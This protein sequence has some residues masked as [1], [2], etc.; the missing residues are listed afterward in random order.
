[1]VFSSNLAQPNSGLDNRTHFDRN[2]LI[3][4][5]RPRN[6]HLC[7]K[8]RTYGDNDEYVELT[9]TKVIEPMFN[10]RNHDDEEVV[11]EKQ[12]DI[13]DEFKEAQNRARSCRR[14]KQKVQ[15]S[16]LTIQADRMATLTTR[17]NIT[18]RQEFFKYFAKWARLVRK[19]FAGKFQYIACAEKQKRGAWHIH[20][21]MDKFYPVKIMQAL[22]ERVVGRGNGNYD[23]SFKHKVS[24]VKI[25]KYIAKYIAKDFAKEKDMS[26]K[27]GRNRYRISQGIQIKEITG[28]MALCSGMEA[29]LL[30]NIFQDISKASSSF[31][32]END[33][34]FYFNNFDSGD[35]Q[36]CH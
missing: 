27:T 31:F 8:L 33:Y 19:Q 25:A 5:D 3:K 32:T 20:L 26:A 6:A 1:M 9:A 14:A 17:A 18:D 15:R 29:Y 23:I 16:C 22:W 4:S 10:R 30:S 35:L 21:A 7:L 34:C 13:P 28:Y 11:F 24:P 2:D 36:Q 12:R